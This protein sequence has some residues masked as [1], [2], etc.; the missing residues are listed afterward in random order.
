MLAPMPTRPAVAGSGTVVTK[1]VLASK[2][3][4]RLG[5]SPVLP[6]IVNVPDDEVPG[7]KESGA[8]LMAVIAIDPAA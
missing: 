4:D 2:V 3:A 5:S 7:A 8:A 1:L 6:V